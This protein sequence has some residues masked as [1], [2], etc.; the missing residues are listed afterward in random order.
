MTAFIFELTLTISQ[1]LSLCRLVAMTHSAHTRTHWRSFVDGV[2]T[3]SMN[4]WY[5][6]GPNGAFPAPFDQQYFLILNLAVGG[7]WPVSSTT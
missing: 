4:Q 3:C 1:Y 2:L 7:N 6:S 5:T